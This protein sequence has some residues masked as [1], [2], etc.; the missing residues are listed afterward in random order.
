MSRRTSPNTGKKYGLKRVC[1]VW[2][3]PRSSF[4]FKQAR[5][6]KNETTISI[7]TRPG[8]KTDISDE[9]LLKLIRRDLQDSP[10]TGEGHRK[11]YG[12]LNRRQGLRVGKKR[13]LRL[14]REHNLLS[15]H[16]VEQG[17]VNPHDGR[18]TTDAPNEMWAAD[19]VKVETA[20]DGWVWVFWLIEHWNTECMGWHVTKRGNRFA[21]LEPITMV[22]EKI[23]GGTGP[24]IAR[25]LQLRI[26]H[27][28]QYKSDD[29]INQI[30]YWGI[31]PNMGFVR[32]PETNGVVERFN[33][34]FKE[35][36]I[37]GRVFRG[38]EDLRESVE[39]FIRDYNKSWLLE[40]LNFKSPLEARYEWEEK[41]QR[42]NNSG[43]LAEGEGVTATS[44]GQRR[45]G[46]GKH[47][48][49]HAQE[50]IHRV[51]SVKGATATSLDAT[52]LTG[53]N[54]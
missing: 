36:V 38:V 20:V 12:R 14:M 17:T 26:D 22:I 34:T 32:E 54:C 53:A 45:S 2:D 35:Q 7:R 46:G 47:I 51:P 37:H 24:D 3:M 52:I 15:P 18:I 10:F 49:P 31:T 48:S 50:L 25:G 29:F 41:E 16:R 13:I 28:S 8:P 1:D 19:G 33:R 4:Y 27:G 30:R 40:K 44:L 11:V 5:I 23:F 21:A 39:K 9:D 42:I 43:M 6:T